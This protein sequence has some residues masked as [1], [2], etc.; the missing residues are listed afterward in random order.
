MDSELERHRQRLQQHRKF[1]EQR[2][3]LGPAPPQP[4]DEDG[5]QQH[6]QAYPPTTSEFE[7][8]PVV[9][10]TD[11]FT[12]PV[13][14]HPHRQQEILDRNQASLMGDEYVA[15][16]GGGEPLDYGSPYDIENTDYN[17]V[18]INAGYVLPT[19]EGYCGP[20]AAFDD[21]V[22][23]VC[24]RSKRWAKMRDEHTA[25]QRELYEQEKLKECSFVPSSRSAEHHVSYQRAREGV[26]VTQAA[27]G[28]DQHLERQQKA[29]Q[30]VSEKS[31]KTKVD[32][33]KW[34]NRVTKPVEF[35]L[36]RR[37]AQDRSK[38]NPTC[39]ANVAP[40]QAVDPQQRALQKTIGKP[41]RKQ[42]EAIVRGC[43]ED[44]HSSLWLDPR[45]ASADQSEFEPAPIVDAKN[46]KDGDQRSQWERENAA[47]RS[48]V[49]EKD[50]QIRELTERLLQLEEQMRKTR[51]V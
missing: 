45:S 50:L 5:S 48:L 30:Q 14:H 41:A 10:G 28:V 2:G 23:R 1:L 8:I 24:E 16:G 21:Q 34:Q 29:R 20:G 31:Q 6:R 42:F 37:T 39:S 19:A 40:G 33:S 47:L 25:R 17:N 32:I 13:A 11:A 46:K 44:S 38:S 43:S 49:V 26:P 3:E 7:P 36:G 27:I 35:K 22:L 4:S 9:V 15:D 18:N 51:V 12:T